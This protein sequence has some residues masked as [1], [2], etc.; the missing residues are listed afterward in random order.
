MILWNYCSICT[1][2]NYAQGKLVTYEYK[3]S[4]AQSDSILHMQHSW[5]MKILRAKL[6]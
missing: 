6:E 4:K 1:S 5:S 2:K 3:P